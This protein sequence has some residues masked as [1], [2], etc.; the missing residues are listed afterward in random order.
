[1]SPKAT[2]PRRRMT[3]EEAERGTVPAPFT[4]EEWDAL[5]RASTTRQPPTPVHPTEEPVRA[6][7][8]RY[9]ICADAVPHP[10]S[11]WYLDTAAML[12]HIATLEAAVTASR[13]KC[14]HRNYCWSAKA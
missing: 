4:A 13:R 6:L 14:T 8:A 10:G 3:T 11:T 2:T 5:R 12:A 1:M 7:M 9:T